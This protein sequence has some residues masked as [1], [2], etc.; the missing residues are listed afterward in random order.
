MQSALR[1]ILAGKKT[2]TA[3]VVTSARRL[4]F[5][6]CFFVKK[7]LPYTKTVLLLLLLLLLLAVVVVV[8]QSSS[9]RGLTTS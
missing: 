4:C 2:V 7:D 9:I 8:V 3:V 6:L 1:L 5:S